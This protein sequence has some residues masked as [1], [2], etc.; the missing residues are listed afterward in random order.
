MAAARRTRGGRGSGSH[1]RIREFL[2][3]ADHPVTAYEILDAVRPSGI[4]APPTV[5][6]ALARLV[7]D[8]HAHRIE[9]LN[10]YVACTK[11]QCRRGMALFMICDRCG[12]ARELIE[13]GVVQRIEACAERGG[14]R[15]DRATVE[16]HGTCGTCGSCV[17]TGG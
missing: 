12:E 5:Y 9:S 2:E 14:F 11:P 3:Q 13:S 15:L 16:L 17:G 7:A 6:R 8:G 10:A 4:S 1:G